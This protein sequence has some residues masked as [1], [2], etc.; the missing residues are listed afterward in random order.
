MTAIIEA[1]AEMGFEAKLVRQKVNRKLK[2]GT[3]YFLFLRILIPFILFCERLLFWG[4][5]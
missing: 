2:V 4:F 5:V 1:M 3:F